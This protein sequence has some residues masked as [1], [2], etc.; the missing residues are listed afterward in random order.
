MYG[1]KTQLPETSSGSRKTNR[2]GGEGVI[3]QL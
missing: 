3:M 1:C 2:P